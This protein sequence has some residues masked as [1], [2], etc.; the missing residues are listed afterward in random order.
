MKEGSKVLTV[1]SFE[2]VR[3]L[4]GYPY[5]RL[6]DILTVSSVTPHPNPQMRNRGIVLLNFEELPTLT[7]VCDKTSNGVQNFIELQ[8][9]EDIDFNVDEAIQERRHILAGFLTKT[10]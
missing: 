10:K 9:K 4:W 8:T 7:G 5:P 3:T 6:G 1:N 2:D